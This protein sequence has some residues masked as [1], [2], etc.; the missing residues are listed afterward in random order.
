MSTLDANLEPKTTLYD[1]KVCRL[2]GEKNDNGRPLFRDCDANDECEVSK[3]INQ[4][5][6]V[7][8]SANRASS[9]RTKH[10][11]QICHSAAG[12]Q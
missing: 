5:L 4:Y 1:S 2:C 8:V 3:L 10:A 7:K 11:N 6:P 9:G 12:P